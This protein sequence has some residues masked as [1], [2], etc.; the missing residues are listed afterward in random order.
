MWKAPNL[1]FFLMTE[2]LPCGW[3]WPESN[4]LRMLRTASGIFVN[5][6]GGLLE[7]GLFLWD[8]INHAYVANIS[9]TYGF[10]S[11]RPTKSEIDPWAASNLFTHPNSEHHT[12]FTTSHN[13]FW[14]DLLLLVDYQFKP[15]KKS[16]LTL[17]GSFIWK[18]NQHLYIIIFNYIYC[19]SCIW[20]S[21]NTFYY[22]VCSV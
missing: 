16:V 17:P 19:K 9:G 14:A 20:K 1:F 2:A 4:I 8:H 6:L 18:S 13:S 7:L 22:D 3:P 11:I 15:S 10:V 5:W 12:D 21:V